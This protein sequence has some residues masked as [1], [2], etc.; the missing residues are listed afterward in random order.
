MLGQTVL[1]KRVDESVK[2]S[3][4]VGGKRMDWRR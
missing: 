1:R 3:K 2:L 4:V